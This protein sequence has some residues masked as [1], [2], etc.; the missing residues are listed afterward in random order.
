MIVWILRDCNDGAIYGIFSSK[1]KA[2]ALK[3]K[4]RDKLGTYVDN[5]EIDDMQHALSMGIRWKNR[6]A[7]IR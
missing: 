5:Y 1:E 7:E 3:E 4:W 2:E 6:R